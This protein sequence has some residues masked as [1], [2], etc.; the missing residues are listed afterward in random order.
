MATNYSPKIVT[1]GLVLALDAANIKSYP[2]SGTAWN[3]MSSIGISA[4]LLGG[5]S[6]NGGTIDFDGVNGY[7]DISKSYINDGTIGTG[8]IGYAMEAWI[9]IRSNAPGV[10][11][12]G[13]S[14]IGNAAAT[15]IGMQ[16]TYVGGTNN[17][18]WM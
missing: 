17:K 2:G 3:D 10:T 9:Q 4:T 15:G 16:V 7:V 18:L 8:N 11:L 13:S 1:E 6:F 12:S 5:C 14:I